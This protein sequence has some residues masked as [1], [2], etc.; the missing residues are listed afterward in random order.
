VGTSEWDYK[1]RS[2]RGMVSVLVLHFFFIGS[3]RYVSLQATIRL[4]S[5]YGN[6]PQDL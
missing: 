6:P 4:T 5:P 3:L 1:G 2:S